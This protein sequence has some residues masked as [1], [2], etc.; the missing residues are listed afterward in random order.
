MPNLAKTFR[1]LH[2]AEDLL[3]LPNAW[4]AAS[5]KVIEDTMPCLYM[6]GHIIDHG[7]VEVIEKRLILHLGRSVFANFREK[8]S[9]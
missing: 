8:T 6:I 4:D 1:A 9:L 2:E 7:T 5:A 3:I